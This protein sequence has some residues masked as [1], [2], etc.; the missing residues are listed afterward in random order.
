MLRA[1]SLAGNST[2]VGLMHGNNLRAHLSWSEISKGKA[3]LAIL[4]YRNPLHGDDPDYHV[5]IHHGDSGSISKHRRQFTLCNNH[6]HPLYR[7]AYY[8]DPFSSGIVFSHGKA[9]SLKKNPE[10]GKTMINRAVTR[11]Y[12]HFKIYYYSQL[13]NSIPTIQK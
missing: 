1:P 6:T 3:G 11:D 8:D 2:M 13:V 10:Y 7:H 12:Y 5:H 4:L 9:S